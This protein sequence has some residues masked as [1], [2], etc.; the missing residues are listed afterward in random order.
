MTGVLRKYTAYL[1]YYIG[2]AGWWIGENAWPISHDV[3]GDN[4]NGPWSEHE[5]EYQFEKKRGLHK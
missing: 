5:Q 4:V 2:C 3:Q 1:F